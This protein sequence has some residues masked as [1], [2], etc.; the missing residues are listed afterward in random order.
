MWDET[1]APA[2]FIPYTER[3]RRYN[4]AHDNDHCT[5]EPCGAEFAFWP[6]DLIPDPARNRTYVTYYM[7][8]R[9]PTIQ[10]WRGVGSSLAVQEGDDTLLQFNT[11][12]TGVADME[13]VLKNF[14]AGDVSGADFVL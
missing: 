1:G 9:A 5:A 11:T 8:W 10:G 13:I 14:D 12:G 6:G 3:E 4:Y 7:L 2:E